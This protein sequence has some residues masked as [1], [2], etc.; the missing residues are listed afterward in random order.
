MANEKHISFSSLK[1]WHSCPYKFKLYKVDGIRSFLGNEH[2][3]FGNAMHTIAEHKLLGKEPFEKT[4]E[5]FFEQEFIKGL[6][7][8]KENGADLNAFN[9]DL[10]NQ[11][12]FQG[13]EL[14]P[15][16][17][18]GL[19]K[20]FGNFDIIGT[21][22]KIELPIEKFEKIDF[23]GYID[24][25]IITQ[26]ERRV[27]ILDYKTTSWGWDNTRKAKA[28][29]GYQLALYKHFFSKM[30]EVD[31]ENIDCHFCLLKRIGKKLDKRVEPFKITTGKKKISNA[32]EVLHGACTSYEKNFFPKNKLSCPDCP[33]YKTVHCP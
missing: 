31:P 6:K 24:L 1:D 11:M 22:I 8:C 23:L 14:I 12:R 26:E 19:K 25:A 17:Y 4:W 21:E 18:P 16:I 28:I 27:H 9:K 15:L 29:T 13:K 7:E 10:I 2:T 33:F 20:Y 30:L 3:A 5:E 32:L